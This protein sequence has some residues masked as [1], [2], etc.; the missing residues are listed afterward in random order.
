MHLIS[1]CVRVPPPTPNPTPSNVAFACGYAMV[2]ILII[3]ERSSWHVEIAQMDVVFGVC[4]IFTIENT[5]HSILILQCHWLNSIH[6]RTSV[7]TSTPFEHLPCLVCLLYLFYLSVQQLIC[8]RL[9]WFW[10]IRYFGYNTSAH[11]S[12]TTFPTCTTATTTCH[13]SPFCCSE[14]TA[15][16]DTHYIECMVA[17]FQ[18]CCILHSGGHPFPASRNSNAHFKRRTTSRESS[19]ISYCNTGNP[20]SIKFNSFNTISSYS[21]SS[22]ISS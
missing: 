7:P 4:P 17:V 18:Q 16:D 3:M 15:S 6:R 9:V 20:V 22:T 5:I 1:P 11:K 2:V 12:T 14:S 13:Q 19:T 8:H 21:L 10:S